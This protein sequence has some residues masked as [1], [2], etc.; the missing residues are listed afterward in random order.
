M[1]LRFNC[2]RALAHIAADAMRWSRLHYPGDVVPVVPSLPRSQSTDAYSPPPDASPLHVRLGE[3][4]RAT[5][6]GDPA[7]LRRALAAEAVGWSPAGTFTYRDEAVRQ[8]LEEVSSLEVEEFRV[9]TLSWHDP[10]LSAE[11]HLV[12]RHSEPL[13]IS[14]DIL[15]DPTERLIRLPGATI[16]EIRHDR[17]VVVHTY[18]DDAALIEQVLLI[19]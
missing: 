5:T 6:V 3:L 12:A 1:R 18:F 4:V 16:A 19:P 2:D 17:V 14:E 7:E 11:W 15:I 13:L 8:S 10:W 9:V